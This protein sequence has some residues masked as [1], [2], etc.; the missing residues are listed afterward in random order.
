MSYIPDS[1][2][3]DKHTHNNLCKKIGNQL[4]EKGY[5]VEF[6]KYVKCPKETAPWQT[7]Y[8]SFKQDHFFVDI[9]GERDG[10]VVYIEC[11]Q[12]EKYK[13]VWL[14]TNMGKTI[15]YPYLYE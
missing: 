11:G 10:E 12:C 14:A 13:L 5:K 7:E 2:R 6:E 15:H 1:W 8:K 9:C 4:I 3:V